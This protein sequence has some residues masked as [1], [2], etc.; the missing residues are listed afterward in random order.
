MIQ[1][2]KA[3]V[4]L[5]MKDNTFYLDIKDPKRY[6]EGNK[7]ALNL[8]FELHDEKTHIVYVNIYT[9]I[10]GENE[11]VAC[12]ETVIGDKETL[13]LHELVDVNLVSDSI[14]IALL[15]QYKVMKYSSITKVRKPIIEDVSVSE[16]ESESWM[17][18]F[19]PVFD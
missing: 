8:L 14:V 15:E 18:H 12:A 17:N 7:R 6:L 1:K 16:Y 10:D 5:F 3:P 19:R 9:M 2:F 11:A 13:M 4:A